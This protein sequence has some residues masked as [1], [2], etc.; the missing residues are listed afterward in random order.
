[1][2]EE[3]AEN[4]SLDQDASTA[5]EAVAMNEE[6][7]GDESAFQD[8]STNEQ[9]PQF[10]C[11]TCSYSTKKE[12][13]FATHQKAHKQADRY[14][15]PICTFSAH[16]PSFIKMHLKKHHSEDVKNPKNVDVPQKTS[17]KVCY[18]LKNIY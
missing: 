6:E 1:M 3:E 8:V 2:N 7:A 5:E 14:S 16:F 18:C 10:K 17:N 11:D 9:P 15:C 4:D 13:A 12:A